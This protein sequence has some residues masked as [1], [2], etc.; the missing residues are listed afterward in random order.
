MRKPRNAHRVFAA[1]L[2]AMGVLSSSA[3][4]SNTAG[5][6][7]SDPTP[8]AATSPHGPQSQPGL[9]GLSGFPVPVN[10][11]G[12]A[13]PAAPQGYATPATPQDPIAIA[14]PPPAQTLT[15]T[16]VEGPVV[17]VIPG[18]YQV[19]SV[20]CP[21]GTT[22]TGGGYGLNGVVSQAQFFK[23]SVSRQTNNNGWQAVL[24]VSPTSPYFY[25]IAAEAT[26]ASFT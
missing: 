10:P 25:Q 23:V 22:V 14:T 6:A 13:A 11:Q 8:P 4:F 15:S 3:L 24:N 19:A 9:S 17:T 20:T 12:P 18:T 26:C 1:S 7:A 2:L 5:A 16:M 21:A